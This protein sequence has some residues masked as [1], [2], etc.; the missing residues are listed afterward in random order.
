MQ[1]AEVE[2]IPLGVFPTPLQ[3]LPRLSAELGGPRVFLKRDDL[4]GRGL[5]GN[6]L[7]K[8]EYAFADARAHGATVVVTSGAVQSNH[9]RLTA[10]A[11]NMLGLKAVLVLRG[12]EP[13][14]PSG[15]LLVDRILG[16]AEVHFVGAGESAGKQERI[17]AVEDEVEEVV[18]RLRAA[19]EVPYVIPNGCRPLHGALGYAGCVL[20]LVVQLREQGLAPDAVVT[21]CGTC[22]TQVGLVLGAQLYAHGETEVVGISVSRPAGE[23]VQRIARALDEA[24]KF[25]D[26]PSAVPDSAITVYDDYVGPGYGVPTPEMQAALTLTARTEG[27]ILD[28]VYTGKAMAGLVDLIR[29][30]RFSEGDVVVLLHTG[31][32]PGLFADAQA[33]TFF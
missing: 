23:L 17:R 27:I 31:G 29:R 14:Q 20:E 25:L 2:R 4:T 28:P 12:E 1:I 32:M 16:P 11:A 21:A 6:K 19:G 3:E 22:S 10:A 7:R 18:A 30:G 8:L 9:C 24:V 15:N 5:G 13:A 33:P 26:L